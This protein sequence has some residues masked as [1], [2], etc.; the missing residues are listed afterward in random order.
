MTTDQLID[1]APNVVRL[2]GY[3][4]SAF[5]IRCEEIARMFIAQRA[6]ERIAA[7][8]RKGRA[9]DTRVSSTVASIC[10]AVPYA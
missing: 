9:R 8:A 3:R 1:I 5:D 10:R 7:V 4:R 2:S 6:A